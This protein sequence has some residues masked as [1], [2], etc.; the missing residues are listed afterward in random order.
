MVNNG[1]LG[2]KIS[3]VGWKEEKTPKKRQKNR[4][5]IITTPT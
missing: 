1:Y 2:K 5:W 4:S 3:K